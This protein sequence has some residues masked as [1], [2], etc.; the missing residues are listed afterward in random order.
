MIAASAV[1]PFPLKIWWL[2]PFAWRRFI[3]SGSLAFSLRP[4]RGGRTFGALECSAHAAR[5]PA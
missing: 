5:L 3:P 2:A 1:S 4:E